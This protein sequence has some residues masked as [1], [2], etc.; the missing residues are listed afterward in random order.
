MTLAGA[1]HLIL[2]SQPELVLFDIGGTLVVEAVPG[3]PT[4]QLHAE[5][6]PGVP[7]LLAALASMVRIGAVTNTAVMSETDVRALLEPCGIAT[8]LEHIVT[9]SD[10]GIAK[11]D[12]KPLLVACERFGIDPSAAVYVG[13]HPVD[14][15]AAEAAGMPYLDVL[16][17]AS[18]AR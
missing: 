2:A 12:P 6:L 4:S 3:T 16:D 14:R 1:H 17:L 11:P 7:E 5:P 9:S 8:H 13:N 10:V 18:D 15:D